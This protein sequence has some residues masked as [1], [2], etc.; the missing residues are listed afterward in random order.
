M[1]NL[2]YK[3]KTLTTS[4]RPCQ[5]LSLGHTIGIQNTSSQTIQTIHVH[6]LTGYSG[7]YH[8]SIVFAVFQ[9]FEQW[10]WESLPEQYTSQPHISSDAIALNNSVTTPSSPPT[11][12]ISDDLVYMEQDQME[13]PTKTVSCNGVIV[14]ININGFSLHI[15]VAFTDC[16]L[17]NSTSGCTSNPKGIGIPFL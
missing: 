13:L 8:A 9:F 1:L 6:A 2:F 17:A 5:L 14:C 10:G 4:L 16:V 7:G 15:H 3:Q 11:D 12:T